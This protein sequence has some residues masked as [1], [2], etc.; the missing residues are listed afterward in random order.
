MS[1]ISVIIPN[2]NRADLVGETIENMLRQSL[3]PAEVI[4][5][6]DGSTDNSVKVIR[7]FG[8]R[9]KLIEQ[10]NQGP[11]AA[12]NAGFA[13]STG[14]FIQFMDSDDLASFNKL[15]VQ[16]SAIKKSGAEFAYCPWVRTEFSGKKLK[17]A[18]PVMQGSA[19][20]DS[21]SMLEWRM[22]SWCLVFQNC[23]FRRTILEKAGKFRT[24]LMPT[25][26]SEYLVRI[27][28]AGGRPVFTSECLVFYRAHATNQITSSG[29][30]AKGRA[31][32]WTRYLEII[33]EEVAE[34]MEAF[35]PTTLMEIALNVYRHNRFCREQGWP[36]V[37]SNSPFSRLVGATSEFRLIW[38]DYCD[39]VQRKLLRL[40]R[41]T[42][43][44]KALALRA[45]NSKDCQLAEELGFKAK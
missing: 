2:Y 39:R 19:I 45:A 11:G 41:S 5:V 35:H 13:A 6:D 4:V 12:R 22:G 36:V 17:F 21:K 7:S 32:D 38:M 16:L 26:D 30:S 31:E 28:L 15:E 23:L 29:T 9:V 18:G 27:L 25:E 40:P 24:D 33:G 14:E 37:N 43:N 44:S 42:P 8:D 34:Q 3:A 20:P 1:R 10:V